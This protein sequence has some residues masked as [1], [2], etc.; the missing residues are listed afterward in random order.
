MQTKNALHNVQTI[1]RVA[2]IFAINID[3]SANRLFAGGVE[4]SGEERVTQGDPFIM[5]VFGLAI[6]TLYY[7]HNT[8]CKSAWYADDSRGGRKLAE[9]K[10]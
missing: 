7:M 3:R 2:A 1:C 10:R 9:I 4:L 8:D 5:I 6:T